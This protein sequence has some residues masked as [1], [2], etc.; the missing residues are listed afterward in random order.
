VTASR[1]G[2][3]GELIFLIAGEASGDALGGRLM[4]ALSE[5][6]GGS[7]RFV[8]VGGEAMSA[9]G[10]ESLYPMEELAVMG[11]LEVVPRIPKLLRRIDETVAAIRRLRPAAVVTID[12][13]SFSLRVARRLKS[14]NGAG[15][16]AVPVVHYV[17]PQVWAWRPERALKLK[18]F[19][20]HLLVL[21]P[22]EAPFF[23]K[24]GVACTYV[25]HPVVESGADKGDGAA[26]RARHG[27]ASDAP[28]ISVLPGSRHSEARRLLPVFGETLK[29]LAERLARLHAVAGAS[30][31]VADEVAEAAAGWPVPAT[32]V[33]GEERFDGFAASDV[34]LAAS[35]TVTL[36]LA[37]AGVPFVVAYR[38]NPVTGWMARR[39]V[40][41]PYANLIN[42]VLGR[43]V[44][45]ELL[46]GECRPKPLAAAV[47]RLVE[48][49][50]ARTEQ[51][52][53]AAEALERLGRGGPSPSRRA[54]EA[55]LAAIADFPQR[56]R[57][58]LRRSLGRGMP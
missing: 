1:T 21:L 49:E 8:G 20:D 27:I 13:P 28:V 56:E 31:A 48:D 58:P 29:R 43:A 52:R 3:N 10:L 36:E 2:E 32:V 37:L 53:A 6:T 35:G 14:A 38:M 40:N 57:L 42:L 33:R 39:L 15:G 25:G 23:E 26:F 24:V 46:L 16:R 45:P 7:V 55:V 17:A 41:V 50:G 12:S 22:F 19:V 11:L 9:Q 51:R 54:A 44:V 18:R 5:L 30:S 34:A 47:L 4:A